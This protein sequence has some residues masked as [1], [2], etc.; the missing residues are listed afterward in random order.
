M[1]GMG[2]KDSYVGDEAMSKRG[3]LSLRSPFERPRPKPSKRDV[4]APVSTEETVA[5]RQE[6]LAPVCTLLAAG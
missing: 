6:R 2:Q 1:V 5:V 4:A 3:I